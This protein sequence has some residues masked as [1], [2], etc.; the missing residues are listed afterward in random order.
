MSMALVAADADEDLPVAARRGQLADVKKLLEAGAPLEGKNQYGAT[1]LYLAV[2]NG[3]T[4]VALLLLEKGAN[5]NV[6]DTFYKSSILDSALQ[7]QRAEIVKA[8]IGKGV[9]VSSR[10]LNMVVGGGGIPT[11]QAALTAFFKPEDLTAALKAAIDAKKAEA[12]AILRKAGAAEPK[13]V[14]V[15]AEA[16]AGYAGEYVSAAIPLPIRVVAEAG[17]LKAQAEGQPQ[18][19]LST[20]SATEFSYAMAGVKMVFDGKG[21]FTMHQGGQQFPFVK[22]GSAGAPVIRKVPE[23]VLAGYAGIYVTD[24]MPMEISVSGQEGQIRIHPTGQA[25]VTLR[26]DSDTEFSFGPGNLR[27]VFDSKGGFTLHQGGQQIPFVKKGSAGAPVARRVPETVLAGY[28]GTYASSQMPLEITVSGQEGNL[29]IQATGQP[30]L[31]LR[32]E[33]DTEFG[34]APANVRVVFSGTEG[35]TLHQG[36]Q[37]FEF[38]KKAGGK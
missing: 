16:L 30:K 33:S 8:L 2:F 29:H 10:Q 38:K 32:S 3:H 6:T 24:Q 4:E 15:A 11:L 31:P 37:E 13:L 1:A 5:P 26:S 28:A 36:G 17:V 22:K 34:F 18:F 21:G 25:Q 9:A 35:F 7:K 12:A 23:T 14:A 20:D 27:V 19:T